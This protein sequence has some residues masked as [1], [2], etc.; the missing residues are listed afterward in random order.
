[1][2][3]ESNEE[4]VDMLGTLS[5]YWW[6]VAL[7]GVVAVA[8]GI[9]AVIWPDVTL[10][11]LVLL[12]GAYALVDEVISLATALFGGGLGGRRRGW[13]VLEGVVGIVAGLI[14]FAWPDITTVAL[15][16]LIAAWAIGTG[17]LELMAAVRLRRELTNEWLLVL[18]GVLSV[19]FGLFLV[20][21]PTEGALAVVWVIGLYAIVFGAA[22]MA[23][24]R[25]LRRHRRSLAAR[26]QRRPA[27]A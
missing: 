6:A 13:L 5:R 20:V 14:T 11:V 16:W 22:L 27:P 3:H 2:I 23:L 1:L 12:F 4:V 18:G 19:A 24:A 15:L 26:D 25:R 8:F 21:R 17:V 10:S 7:R 9:V